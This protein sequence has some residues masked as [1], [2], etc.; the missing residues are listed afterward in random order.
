MNNSSHIAISTA[1][2]TARHT[3]G[4]Q[5]IGELC[6]L[7]FE[8]FELAAGTDKSMLPSIVPMVESG[9][10]E[11][12][13]LH[14]PC[15]AAREQTPLSAPDKYRREAAVMQAAETIKWAERFGARL[16]VLHAGLVEINF[17][18]KTAGRLIGAGFRAEGEAI[19]K[20][21]M[22]RRNKV[23]EPFLKSTLESLG[24]LIPI[25]S[26]A[27]VRL[28][29]ETRYYY[30]EIPSLEEFQI[31]FDELD[32][33]V[34]GYWHDTGHE[35][36]QETLGLAEKGEYLRRYSGRMAGIHVHDAVNSSDHRAVGRGEIEF[37]RIMHSVPKEARIVLE[38]HAP[39]SGADL[40]K[41]RERIEAAL[42]NRPPDA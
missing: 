14:N 31:I 7:G 27:G 2:N 42:K 1:W 20:E 26:A 22:A 37:D 17:E 34:L 9:E 28:G 16:V 6:N 41:S 3:S 5:V 36:V 10:I 11:V 23:R 21:D 13:S 38:V 18:Q 32:S 40:V 30:T 12:V 19:V 33:P 39:A 35:H 4:S 8:S 24:E 25:A 29:L 15:P